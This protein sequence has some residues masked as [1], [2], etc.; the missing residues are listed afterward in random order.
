MMESEMLQKARIFEET[1]EK[2]ITAE[3][4]PA[5]HLTPRTGW[6]NDPNGLIW[7]DGLYHL[8]YQYY[9]Y[10]THWGP[11]HWGHVV[12]RDL[13]HWTYLPAAMAPDSACDARGC[14]SGSSVLLPDGRMLLVYTGCSR[15]HPEIPEDA[16]PAGE[17]VILQNQCAALQE[18]DEFVKYSGNPVISGA[19]LPAGSSRI[20]FRDPKIIRA[21]DGSWLCV[22]SCRPADG[23]GQILLYRS[24]DCLHWTYKSVLASNQGRFG[25]MWECPDFF[26]LDGSSVLLTSPQDMLPDG[27]EYA[28]GNGTLCL[29]GVYDEE[30]GTFTEKTNQAV[31]YGIDFYAMQTVVSPDGR[32]IMIGWMQNWDTCTYRREHQKWF[33][34]MSLPRE[35][36]IRNGR[37][38]QQPVRELKA[39]REGSGVRYNEILSSETRSLP[40][41]SGRL[42]DLELTIRAAEKTENAGKEAGENAGKEAGENAGYEAF[43]MRFAEKGPYYMLVTY[44]PRT[45]VLRMDRK[46]SDFRRGVLYERSCIAE[47]HE[48]ALKLR[49]ILDR[50]SA[51]LFV[52]DGEKVMTFTFYT[53]DDAEGIS[54]TAEGRLRL[55]IAAFR[56]NAATADDSRTD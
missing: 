20:D 36:S 37:L 39:L 6:M 51:E 43:T 14:F 7:A 3:E 31:D 40:G 10:D 21:A 23:S 45:K 33:G 12:S 27:F 9:P 24:E 44:C 8:F 53:E 35:I 49:L 18:G 32:R 16:V 34:Q 52:N 15:E 56:L 25:R 28:S 5:F 55:E 29:T 50:F 42:L 13:L 54:F 17:D 4:R 48:G 22:V 30:S 19:S 47:T 11:M 1:A 41:V 46:H 2:Q 26:E 38:F